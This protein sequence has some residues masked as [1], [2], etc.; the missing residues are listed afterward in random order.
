MH[1]IEDIGTPASATSQIYQYSMISDIPDTANASII[2]VGAN[3]E[4]DSNEY[5]P[6]EKDTN[7]DHNS[8]SVNIEDLKIKHEIELSALRLEMD[9]KLAQMKTEYE[10]KIEEAKNGAPEFTVENNEE[11]EQRISQI[12]SVGTY[13]L[14]LR[15]S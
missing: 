10:T 1:K 13:K 9:D 4:I 11:D 8:E 2:N 7:F 6:S 12:L 5:R 15:A 3:D 14:N